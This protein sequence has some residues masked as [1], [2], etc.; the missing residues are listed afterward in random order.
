MEWH[1][2]NFKPSND[3]RLV[4]TAA[5]HLVYSPVKKECSINEGKD[6]ANQTQNRI[7]VPNSEQPILLHNLF[8]TPRLS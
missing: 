5:P 6:N 3:E 8:S 2:F 4:S 7:T 1:F